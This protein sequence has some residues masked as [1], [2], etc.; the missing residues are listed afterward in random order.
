MIVYKEIFQTYNL[1]MKALTLCFIFICSSN[2]FSKECDFRSPIKTYRPQYATHFSIKYF[3][4]FKIVSVDDNQYLLTNKSELGC[5]TTIPKIVSPVKRIVMMS[6]TYLPALEILKQEK[7]LVGFQGKHY[8]VSKAFNIDKIIDIS[9]K[10][11]PEFLI[12]LKADLIMGS[13]S[14]LTAENQKI[15]FS[16]LNLPVTINKDFEETSP[17]ARAEWLI[18]ISSFFDQE[19]VAITFFKSIEK[20]YLAIKANNLKLSKKIDVLVGEIQNGMWVTCG[21]QSDLGKMIE[22]AGGTLALSRPSALTQTLS[23]EIL[24]K[25]K[26]SFDLWLTHNNWSSK[27]ERDEAM[28]KDSRYSMIKANKTYNNNLL[29]NKFNSNDFW[30]TGLQ[31]PDLLLLDLSLLFHPENY[32]GLSPHWYRSI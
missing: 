14:N 21:E 13:D 3:S 28:K 25:N 2:L 32:S 26:K 4:H 6:T 17:L 12:N 24:S 18:Y 20:K 23:L 7:T 31:R 15:I 29:V 27:I 8:I 22:D 16:K 19:E 5:D 10:F 9:F 30:E 11:N 1:G